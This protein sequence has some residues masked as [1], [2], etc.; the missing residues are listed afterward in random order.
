MC[1]FLVSVAAKL[2]LVEHYNM[3]VEEN[4]LGE[5]LLWAFLFMALLHYFALL[6]GM[7]K[8]VRRK[9]VQVRVGRIISCSYYEV[10][11]I[12]SRTRTGA[13]QQPGP[14]K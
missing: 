7:E 4:S 1:F 14:L 12:N 3:R 13:L 2:A 11:F 10:T 9:D 6:Y 8:H 5:H